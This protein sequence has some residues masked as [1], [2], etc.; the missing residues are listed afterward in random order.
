MAPQMLLEKLTAACPSLNAIVMTT[1]LTP[2]FY[3]TRET[4]SLKWKRV[5]DRSQSVCLSLWMET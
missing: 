3:Y 1:A 5:E 4:S 2:R